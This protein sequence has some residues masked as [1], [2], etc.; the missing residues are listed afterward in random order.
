MWCCADASG[1][2]AEEVQAVT[3]LPEATPVVQPE[4]LKPAVKAEVSVKEAKVKE[5]PAP[6]FGPFSVQIPMKGFSSLG[7]L[8]DFTSDVRPMVKTV[9]VGAVEK[10]N[11]LNPSRSIQ[12]YDVIVALDEAAN[13]SEIF[14][15]MEGTLSHTVN[16]K[17][18]RP[19]K[20]QV[21]I[22]KTEGLG[23][24]LE[25]K[26]TS[27]GAVINVV[28]SSGPAAKW[29]SEH[30]NEALCAGDRILAV[31]GREM[32]GPEMLEQIKATNELM[33]TANE[34]LVVHQGL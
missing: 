15:K 14:Q 9:E 10:F 32:V 13:S 2:V 28:S 31:N 5:E 1:T 3:A 17:L 30:P 12:P 23:L 20:Q 33:L 4:A 22:S 21:P 29:N 24:K 19:K 34:V 8:L 27:L 7:L 25:Y 16:L 11:E 26:S 18:V 6:E